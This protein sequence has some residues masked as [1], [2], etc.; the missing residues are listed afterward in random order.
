MKRAAVI[1]TILIL[2]A[3]IMLSGCGM[4]AEKVAEKI[5][6]KIVTVY[7]PDGVLMGKMGIRPMSEKYRGR[8]INDK[9]IIEYKCQVVFTCVNERP[10]TVTAFEIFDTSGRSVGEFPVSPFRLKARAIERFVITI[11]S[12]Y[13]EDPYKAVIK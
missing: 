9:K 7:Y 3:G 5:G 2:T 4:I 8:D 10:L 6:M 13:L 12:T 11:P 1:L